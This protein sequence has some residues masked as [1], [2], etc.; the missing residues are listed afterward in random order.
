[1]HSLHQLPSCSPLLISHESRGKLARVCTAPTVDRCRFSEQGILPT[2]TP[3]FYHHCYIERASENGQAVKAWLVRGVVFVIGSI[4]VVSLMVHYYLS[5][6]CNQRGFSEQ[7][8]PITTT[9]FLSSLHEE[10]R[11][12]APL[13]LTQVPSILQGALPTITLPSWTPHMCQIEYLPLTVEKVQAALDAF[14]PA[15]SLQAQVSGWAIIK[16]RCSFVATPLHTH[17]A[18]QIPTHTCLW[19][20]VKA[21]ATCCLYITQS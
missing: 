14:S 13:T 5:G 15:L 6:D 2:T 21:L 20:M 19:S 3:F 17:L 4:V 10:L 16:K 8:S 18:V 1:M 12:H 7:G 9:P 11:A